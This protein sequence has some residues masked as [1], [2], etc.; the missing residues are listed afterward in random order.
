MTRWCKCRKLVAEFASF[1]EQFVR[2]IAL[3]PVFKLLEMFGIFEIRDRNL[4]CTPGPLHRLAIHE[5]WPGPAFWRTEHDHGPTR[6][7]HRLWRGTRRFLDLL[8]LCQD[9]IKRAG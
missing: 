3:H 2:P 9:R 1:V 8:Y 6:P 5:L 4:V 7:L